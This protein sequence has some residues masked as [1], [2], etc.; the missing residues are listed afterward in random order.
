MKSVKRSAAMRF[1]AAGVVAGLMLGSATVALAATESE[2]AA[3]SGLGIRMGQA[4]KDAGARLVDILAELTGLS[5]DEV[6]AKRA[7]GLSAAQI[8]EENGVSVDEVTAS[9][10][11][12]RKAILDSKVADGS[13]TQEQADAAYDRMSDRIAERVTTTETGAPSWAGQG[14]GSRGAG[15]GAGQG[16]GMR[17]AGAGTCAVTD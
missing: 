7:E 17:G 16:A 13:I 14:R 3:T 11:D 6:T 1:V 10:L 5:A 12:A 8:A 4:I 9:A 2:P 15:M